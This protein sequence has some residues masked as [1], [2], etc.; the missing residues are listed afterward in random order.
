MFLKNGPESFLKN[1]KQRKEKVTKR[2]EIQY[3]YNTLTLPL[4]I[5]CI[6]TT[7]LLYPYYILITLLFL[8]NTLI[9]LLSIIYSSLLFSSL[10]SLL[11]FFLFLCITFFI[12]LSFLF[13]N[14]QKPMPFICTSLLS[15][16]LT[17]KRIR[18]IKPTEKEGEGIF[19]RRRGD[20]SKIMSFNR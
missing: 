2:K 12:L 7:S 8:F 3:I 6:L 10:F 4:I 14:I 1:L 18:H 13:R 11:F 20:I 5:Y 17:I 15:C 9:P 16:V 19:K